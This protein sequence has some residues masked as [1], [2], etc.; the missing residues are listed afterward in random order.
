MQGCNYKAR[1]SLTTELDITLCHRKMCRLPCNVQCKSTTLLKLW[2]LDPRPHNI[3]KWAYTWAYKW[4]YTWGN[5][6]HQQFNHVAVGQKT[7]INQHRHSCILRLQCMSARQKAQSTFRC[8][9]L[10]ELV[11]ILLSMGKSP[12]PRVFMS[13]LMRSPPKMRKRL[14]SRDRK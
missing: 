12:T 7:Q 3:Y 14:S 8:A 2:T 4:A 13:D 10:R 1:M 11:S 6:T 5:Q 9:S